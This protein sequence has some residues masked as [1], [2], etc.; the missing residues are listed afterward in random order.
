MCALATCVGLRIGVGVWKRV[1]V[2][3]GVWINTRDRRHGIVGRGG[4]KFRVGSGR[5]RIDRHTAG[6]PPRE[7]PLPHP[8]G[9]RALTASDSVRPPSAPLAVTPDLGSALVV[10]TS[11]VRYVAPSSAEQDVA[12]G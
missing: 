6:L 10:A 12:V 2:G 9:D 1:G 8:K 5:L 4:I 3:I 11:P 7:A